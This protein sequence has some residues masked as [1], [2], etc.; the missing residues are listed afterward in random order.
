MPAVLASPRTRQTEQI[1]LAGDHTARPCL[2]AETLREHTYKHQAITFV[3]FK[4]SNFGT[5]L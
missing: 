1:V 2:E 5:R 4:T 3:R